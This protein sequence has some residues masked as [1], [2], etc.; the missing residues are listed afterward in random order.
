MICN[1]VCP[2]LGGSR[3]VKSV[4]KKNPGF[5]LGNHHIGKKYAPTHC[6]LHTDIVHK[7]YQFL[8]S[9][10]QKILIISSLLT[11]VRTD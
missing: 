5:H 7:T 3:A 9:V 8:L 10:R 1:F 2:G 4:I 11:Q 6:A